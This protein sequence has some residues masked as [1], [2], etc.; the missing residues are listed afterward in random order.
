M[1]QTASAR[2]DSRSR[3]AVPLFLFSLAAIGA[4]AGRALTTTYLP[5]LLERIQDAPHLIGAVM[6]VNAIAG[7]AVPIAVGLWSDRRGRRLPFMVGGALLSGGGLVAVGFGNG[8][9]Y[10]VLAL[11]AGLVYTGL[12]A[13][14]TAHRAI[15]AEDVEDRRRP[16]A[17]SAQE[18]AGLAGAVLAVAI[19]GALIEPAPT[20]AFALTA[21]VLAASAVPTLLLTRRLRLGEHAAP[22]SGPRERPES[23]RSCG[24]RGLARCCW[25]RPCGCSAMPPCR[26]SSC[27]MPRRAWAWSSRP[28]ARFRWPSGH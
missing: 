1:S 17:T 3:L 2:P 26:P 28:P 14:T 6:T 21:G 22:A 9:S 13:L 12:N 18:I 7:F 15:V 10:L 19:G 20:A 11:S 25:P 16:A 8:S 27:S 5:V 24:T 23:A 4:G